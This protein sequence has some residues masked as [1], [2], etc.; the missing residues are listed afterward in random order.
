MLMPPPLQLPLEVKPTPIFREL[1]FNTSPRIMLMPFTLELRPEVKITPIFGV[2]PF[3]VGPRITLMPFTLQLFSVGTITDITMPAIL[4]LSGISTTTDIT[5]M[6]AAIICQ[7]MSTP[8]GTPTTQFVAIMMVTMLPNT[9]KL[10]KTPHQARNVRSG[11]TEATKEDQPLVGIHVDGE[12]H[13]NS[14]RHGMVRTC[15]YDPDVD[16]CQAIEQRVGQK[17]S[18]YHTKHTASE[19]IVIFW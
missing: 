8:A 18:T 2:L 4:L 13:A 16:E 11:L 9:V 15:Q 12:K 6:T 14:C 7:S 17:T 19:S 1:P 10:V 5:M 3:N